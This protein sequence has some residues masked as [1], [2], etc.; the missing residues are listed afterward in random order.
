MI[1]E[2]PANSIDVHF[3]SGVE[4]PVPVGGFSIGDIILFNIKRIPTDNE[5]TYNADAL[6]FKCALHVPTNDFGSRQ[7]YIK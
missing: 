3:V 1:T 2:I 6:F 7:R 4:L 5:D